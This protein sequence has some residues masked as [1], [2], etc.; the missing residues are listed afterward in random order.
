M[1]TVDHFATERWRDG[2][3]GLKIVFII[4]IKFNDIKKYYSSDT[5]Y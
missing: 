4:I 5:F 3:G 1:E 2:G